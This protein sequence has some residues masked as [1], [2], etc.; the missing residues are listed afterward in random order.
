LLTNRGGAGS[1]AG[2]GLFSWGL[3]GEVRARDGPTNTK[4]G[5][6]GKPRLGGAKASQTRD[7]GLVRGKVEVIKKI[8]KRE[9][10]KKKV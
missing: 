8:T 2:L 9:P 3:G 6:G 7:R 1:V 5:T 4:K 10:V